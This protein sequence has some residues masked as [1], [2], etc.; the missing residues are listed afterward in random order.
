MKT[1]GSIWIYFVTSVWLFIGLSG[2]RIISHVLYANQ[3]I[4]NYPGGY[5]FKV[6]IAPFFLL[7]LEYFLWLKMFRYP[8]HPA[9]MF[10]AL[11]GLYIFFMV[12]IVNAIVADLYDKDINN[13][14]L[15]LYG[16]AALGHISFALFG[17]ERQP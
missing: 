15:V 9:R 14:V 11:I 10:A 12:I 13:F 7:G 16:Y 2:Y 8:V 3:I 5:D 17:R 1:T 6:F 4:G